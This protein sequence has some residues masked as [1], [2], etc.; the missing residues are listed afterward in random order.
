MS[1]MKNAMVGQ[2]PVNV[3]IRAMEATSDLPGDVL[4]LLHRAFAYMEARIDPPSSLHRLSVERIREDAAAGG[5]I[6]AFDGEALVG[7]VFVRA[8]GDA[9]Y[10]GKL[11]V[12]PSRQGQGI[13]KMLLA[14]AER[15]AVARGLSA[16]TLQTRVEL[17]ENHQAFA[18]AG[19]VKT[20]ETAHDGYDR[21]TSI[22]MTK[23]I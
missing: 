15:R 8:H 11:A 9:L 19:F 14:E 20:G 22:T 17:T 13:G 5:L 18:R 10:V 6:G 3:S 1:E 16:L 7:C 2:A 21:P 23:L 4:D 12:E